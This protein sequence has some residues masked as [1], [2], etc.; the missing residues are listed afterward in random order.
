MDRNRKI[1]L[2]LKA[3]KF[4]IDL[5]FKLLGKFPIYRTAYQGIT[6]TYPLYADV[7]VKR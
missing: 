4:D 5:A 3:V 2:F 6:I 1:E 7:L